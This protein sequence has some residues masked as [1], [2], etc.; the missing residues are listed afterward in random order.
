MDEEL[1]HDFENILVPL[2][3]SRH[4]ENALRYSA[5]I[6]KKF[7]SNLIILSIFSSKDE[8]SFFK[9]RIK[10]MN[11]KL[12]EDIEKMPE[13]YLMETYHDILK[14]VVKNQGIKVKS[15]LKDNKTSTKSV[16]SI[17]LEILENEKIDLIVMS[18]YGRSGLTKLK[19]GSV[20][21]ELMKAID[22]PILI[23]KK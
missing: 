14:N 11:Q 13:T 19:M 23:V 9:Q 4:S 22:I 17:L 21:E 7:N 10:E 5:S 3:G 15:F 20:T 6:A 1:F 16:I 2:D 12:I 8:D 18:P